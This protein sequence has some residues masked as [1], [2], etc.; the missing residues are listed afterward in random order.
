MRF[1]QDLLYRLNVF[2]LKVPPLRERVG[3]VPLLVMFFLATFNKKF[4][5]KVDRI[6]PETMQR[7][8]NYHWPGNVREL[9]N[10]IERA[11]ILSN[12]SVLVLDAE[13]HLAT[14]PE[15]TVPIALE[16]PDPSLSSGS[17]SLDDI[18]K[19]H[20]LSV[21]ARTGGI[22]EGPKGAAKILGVHPNTLRSRI[23]KLGITRQSP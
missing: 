3:D 17:T 18:T 6:P 1:R 23:Q 2:P 10:V 8:V 13:F 11:M 5:K 7:L 15:A 20:I 9:Q 14:G 4:G 12:S 21:L 22:I 19:R 16:Q